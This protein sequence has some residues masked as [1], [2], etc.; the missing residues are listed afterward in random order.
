MESVSVDLDLQ[1]LFAVN[2]LLQIFDGLV[3]YQGL[4]LGCIEAN[5]L[6]EASFVASGVLPTLLLF[7]AEACGLLLLLRRS[8]PRPVAFRALRMLAVAYCLCSVFPWL[9]TL[10]P[11]T[12]RAGA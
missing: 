9:G 4:Q 2:I 10:I 6:L 5:P 12:V 3:T 11:L 1:R 8:A 7:K